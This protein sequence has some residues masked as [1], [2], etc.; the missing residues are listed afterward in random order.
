MIMMIIY[1]YLYYDYVHYPY[2]SIH[3]LDLRELTMEYAP[4]SV[5]ACKHFHS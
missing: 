4:L 3:S 1:D 5:W 2:V